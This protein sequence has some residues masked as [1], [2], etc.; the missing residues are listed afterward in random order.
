MS[1][2]QDHRE[3]SVRALANARDR[4]VVRDVLGFVANTKKWWLVPLLIAFAL[5][6]ALALLGSTGLAPFIYPLF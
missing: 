1:T 2:G 4:G 5:F 6:S 3:T